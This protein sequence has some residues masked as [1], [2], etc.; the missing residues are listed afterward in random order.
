MRKEM[1]EKEEILKEEENRKKLILENIRR[2]EEM[3]KQ[4]KIDTY[5]KRMEIENRKA[6]DAE[7]R[8]QKKENERK[9][10]LEEWHQQK[11]KGNA[12]SSISRE[13]R[14]KKKYRVSKLEE[15]AI[16]M[17]GTND[18]R[19]S[20]PY[21]TTVEGTIMGTMQ[22]EEETMESQRNNQNFSQL[23]LTLAV[24]SPRSKNKQHHSSSKQFTNQNRSIAGNDEVMSPMIKGE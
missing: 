10:A 14:Q 24:R 6:I 20:K 3:R 4:I 12:Q 7:K 13:G 2:K 1:L 23:T 16:I 8:E 21:S 18:S 15:P 11:H 17:T 19:S 22:T 5:R 9:V